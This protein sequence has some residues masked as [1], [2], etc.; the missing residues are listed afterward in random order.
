MPTLLACPVFRF[1]RPAL[2]KH[3]LDFSAVGYAVVR[4][5]EQ[6]PDFK[7]PG[8]F[9]REDSQNPLHGARVDCLVHSSIPLA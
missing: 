9:V 1:K 6:H 3:A 2:S 4:V 5:D 8:D 7:L